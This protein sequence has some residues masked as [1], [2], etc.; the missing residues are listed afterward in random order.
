MSR[1]LFVFKKLLS[2]GGSTTAIRSVTTLI[3][4]DGVMPLVTDLL[5]KWCNEYGKTYASEQEKR[6]RFRNPLKRRYAF[7][8]GQNHYDD[9]NDDDNIDEYI[10]HKYMDCGPFIF[11]QE[12]LASQQVVCCNSVFEWKKLFQKFIDTI[13]NTL[14]VVEFGVSWLRPILAEIAKKTPHVIFLKVD[15]D[16]H[17][18]VAQEY[19]INTLPSFV[20]FKEGWEIDRVVIRKED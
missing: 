5:D 16:E 4:G 11:E 20:F 13:T 12:K 2:G 14:V 6:Q 10:H 7:V 1:T 8:V 19:N 15:A 3:P 18:R 9:D 17:S